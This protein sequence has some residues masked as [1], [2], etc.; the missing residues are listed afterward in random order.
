[1]IAWPV[2]YGQTGVMS[3]MVNGEDQVYQ[4]DLGSES[5]KKAQEIKTYHPDKGWQAVAP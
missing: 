1:M 4:T 2:S 5:Q 3:F